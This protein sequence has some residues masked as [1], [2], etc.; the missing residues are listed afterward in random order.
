[1]DLNIFENKIPIYCGSCSTITK[2]V[3]ELKRLK[4]TNKYIFI[5]NGSCFYF[6]EQYLGFYPDYHT[7]LDPTCYPF[8][9]FIYNEKF[10]KLKSKI[11]I[12]KDLYEKI[13][14]ENYKD[15]KNKK[16]GCPAIYWSEEIWNKYVSFMKK[17][18]KE[19]I[20]LNSKMV[21]FNYVCE[22]TKNDIIYLFNDRKNLPDKLSNYILPLI[23]Y[24][25]HKKCYIIGFDS[26][27][28][29]YKCLTGKSHIVPKE[30]G[31][32]FEKEVIKIN[33]FKYFIPLQIK[34]IS[35]NT[36]CFNLTEGSNLNNYIPY[37]NIKEL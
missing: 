21:T 35:I 25:K 10:N 33:K 17:N 29:R 11:I 23:K 14:N 3:N 24:F 34:K 13:C 6:F 26:I 28:G 30:Y 32:N 7:F 16:W 36:K 20:I 2:Y 8:R 9:E 4:K 19:L 22:T 18:R 27:G 5:T 12:M 31:Y 15:L 1:M 37:K